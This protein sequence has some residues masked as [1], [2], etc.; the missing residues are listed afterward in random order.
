MKIEVKNSIKPI[1]YSKA[2]VV[3][4]QRVQDVLEGK[5]NE[6][7]WILEHKKVYTAG[8]RANNSEI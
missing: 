1:D 5:K 3:L 7:L 8:L 6:L 2:M 4:E